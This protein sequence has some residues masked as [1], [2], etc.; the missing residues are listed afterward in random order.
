MAEVFHE[1]EGGRAV[2]GGL[3]G[4]QGQGEDA[5][6]EEEDEQ[7]VQSQSSRSPVVQSIQ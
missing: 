6:T 3:R 4:G 5:A 2:S 7:P 1:K